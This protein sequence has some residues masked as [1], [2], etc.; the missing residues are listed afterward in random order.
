M[1]KIIKIIIVELLAAAKDLEHTHGI[2]KL[3]FFNETDSTNLLIVILTL[4][5]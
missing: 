1:N 4:P 5:V 2:S 3:S